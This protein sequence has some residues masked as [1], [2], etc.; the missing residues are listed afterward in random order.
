MLTPRRSILSYFC[1]II[2][3]KSKS[4]ALL[5]NTTGIILRVINDKC[6]F[7]VFRFIQIRTLVER[8]R[9]RRDLT[10]LRIR[11]R[12]VDWRRGAKSFRDHP[13]RR[14]SDEES[15]AAASVA[16]GIPSPRET[17]EN[18]YRSGVRSDSNNGSDQ[19]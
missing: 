9:H 2:C 19:T 3:S 16:R 4:G 14:T 17:T 1:I 13:S 6:N 11:R 18:Q 10:L 8:A 12:S 15:L 7:L 5:C